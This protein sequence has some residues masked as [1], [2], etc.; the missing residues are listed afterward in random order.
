MNRESSIIALAEQ[1]ALSKELATRIVD[2]IYEK[3]LDAKD[4]DQVLWKLRRYCENVEL[5]KL[6]EKATDETLNVLIEEIVS[7]RFPVPM[8]DCCCSEAEFMSPLELSEKKTWAAGDSFDAQILRCG[9]WRHPVYGKFVIKEKN[10]KNMMKHFDNNVRGVDIMFDE[11]HDPQHKAVTVVKKLYQ[12]GKG[13]AATLWGK[14][15]LTAKGAALFNEGAYRY[16]SAEFSRNFRDIE[17]GKSYSDL[18]LGG[19]VTNRPVVK[20]MEPIPLSESG[21]GSAASKEKSTSA[22]AD[23]FLSVLPSKPMKA[24]LD[25]LNSLVGKDVIT[26]SE[27]AEFETAWDALSD[28]QKKI[29]EYKKAHK[30]VMALQLSEEEETDDDTEV[31]D[32]E[33]EETEGGDDD[34]EEKD[35]K[36]EKKD[37]KA[38][39]RK[40]GKKPAKKKKIAKDDDQEDT[41]ELSEREELQLLRE[42]KSELS[43]RENAIRLSE[44]NDA[45]DDIFEFSEGNAE[46]AP[47]TKKKLAN[48]AISLSE[49]QEQKFLDLLKDIKVVMLGEIG[50]GRNDEGEVSLSENHPAVQQLVGMGYELSE[51]IS[52]AEEA[53]FGK[54]PAKKKVEKKD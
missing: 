28:D 30:D 13:A 1:T 16:I 50:I 42:Q 19:A 23:I 17:T 49:K 31:D 3:G 40:H 8:N 45:V 24:F 38:S 29:P 18:L 37:V 20:G 44:A 52:I 2:A 12:K 15:E 10:I 47:A 46:L 43:Q 7:T 36:K 26:A 5:P 35:E 6:M 34:T 27:R 21:G 33:E 22:N 14:M 41:L 53:K 32:D 4:F 11:D 48:F 51:A 9:E 39:E 25:H 54:K